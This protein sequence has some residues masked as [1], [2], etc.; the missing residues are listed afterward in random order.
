[1]GK[2]FNLKI[3]KLSEKVFMKYNEALKNRSL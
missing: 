3:N 2:I 1:M